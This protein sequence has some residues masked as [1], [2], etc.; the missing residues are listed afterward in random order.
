MTKLARLIV[1]ELFG[2]VVDDWRLAL[3]IIIWLAIVW[4]AL[5]PLGLEGAVRGIALFAGLG[6]ILAE[7]SWRHARQLAAVAGQSRRRL[8]TRRGAHSGSESRR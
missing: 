4:L 7:S 5:P 2:L 6:L 8:S 3:A 1:R